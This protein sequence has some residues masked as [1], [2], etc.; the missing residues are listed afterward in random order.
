MNKFKYTK[1][2][3]ILDV[4]KAHAVSAVLMAFIWGAFVSLWANTVGGYIFTVIAL[5]SY[6][7]SIYGCGE[8]AAKNDRKPYVPGEPDLKKSLYIPI[9]TIIINGIFAVMYKLTWVLGS[10]GENI[11]EVWSVVTNIFSYLWFA[12]FGELT[13]MNKGN[14]AVLGIVAIVLIPEVMYILGYFAGMKN[15]DIN[16]KLFG[17]M[18]EKKKEKK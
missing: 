11:T 16:E 4:L 8:R 6:S 17:F 2:G 10:N 15:F 7:L 3:Q 9:L 18:Y 13:G 5:F 14:F 1:F 12:P